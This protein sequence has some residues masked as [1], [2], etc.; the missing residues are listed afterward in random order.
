MSV[1]QHI[2]VA[3]DFSSETGRVIAKAQEMSAGDAA[4]ISL[5]HVVEYS[6]YLFPP[7][8]PLPVDYDLEAQF[9]EQ[10]RRRLLEL[11]QE[12]GLT[13]AERYVEV[14]S[15][16]LEIVRVA[17]EQDVDLIIVGSHGRHG[18]QRVLG[19]TA[20]GVMHTAPCDVLA[21]RI[22]ESG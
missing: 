19:S 18:L 17:W 4:R 11:A 9:C 5:I 12:R 1:Y 20:S 21:V 15:P 10:A 8:T 7:D 13:T 6:P 2:L 3:I 16:T 22:H 14:G